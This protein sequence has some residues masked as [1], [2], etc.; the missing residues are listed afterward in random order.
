MTLLIVDLVLFLGIH[1]VSIIARG[2]R[3]GMT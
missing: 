3:D 2:W 1:A